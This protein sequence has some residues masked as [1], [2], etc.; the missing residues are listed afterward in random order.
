[1]S[2]KVLVDDN[3]HYMDESER[4][5]LGEFPT[6]DAAIAASTK[7]VDEYLLSAYRPGVTAQELAHSYFTFGEDPFI[8]DTQDNTRG[9]LFSAWDYA[10]RR[11]DEMC[12]PVK[13]QH[14]ERDAL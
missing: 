12:M 11:C 5:T 7:I 1:M 13:N 4:Y 10:R 14:T 8:V 6:L 9:A 3:F 2:Y